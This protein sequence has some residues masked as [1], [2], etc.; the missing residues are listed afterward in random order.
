[1]A[2]ELTRRQA[3]QAGGGAVALLA[4]APLAVQGA[5]VA[6]ATPRH[7][8]RRPWVLAR[9][10]RIQLPGTG[11]WLR[12]EE[13]RDFG[14]GVAALRGYAGRD[15]AFVV[16]L[17]A[18]ASPATDGGVLAMEHPVLGRFAL[19]LSPS[20][21]GGPSGRDFTIVINRVADPRTLERGRHAR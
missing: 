1:M 4:L 10:S 7:L 17:R 3:L 14:A 20:G 21:A 13:V 18:P 19:L 8:Q 11:G 6:P 2:A 12:V 15:D 9:G 5:A 16:L